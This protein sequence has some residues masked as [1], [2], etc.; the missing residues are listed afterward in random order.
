M[1]KREQMQMK[2]RL[3]FLH[4]YWKSTRQISPE[5][6]HMPHCISIHTSSLFWIYL[7]V[8]SMLSMAN[9]HMYTCVCL[10]VHINMYIHRGGG[11]EGWEKWIHFINTFLHPP[12]L[13]ISKLGQDYR[14]RYKIVW[15]DSLSLSHSVFM[16][17][18]SEPSFYW[19]TLRK[20]ELW[21]LSPASC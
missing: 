15:M 17:I 13:G 2:S 6:I 3:P 1:P 21:G 5:Q 18:C 8:F 20:K 19:R 4:I 10:H 16:E 11:R 7:W 12:W 9:I 14:K